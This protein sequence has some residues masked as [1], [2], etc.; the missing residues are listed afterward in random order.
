M[1]ERGRLYF[2]LD[3]FAD[4]VI[5][6][7]IALITSVP[8]I[9]IGTSIASLYYAL[10]K[11]IKNGEGKAIK[12]YLKVWA[13]NWKK[14]SILTGGYIVFVISCNV[15]LQR[16]ENSGVLFGVMLLL[17]ICSMLYCFP[18]IGRTRL[19]SIQCLQ[20]SLFW[21]VHH[22]AKTLFL[23]LN[24]LLCIIVFLIYPF[25]L[26]ILLGMFTYYISF[27]IEKILE[28]YSEDSN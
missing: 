7:I 2:A 8:I 16:M 11:S 14:G 13:E 17:L 18:L 25:F 9:T 12:L 1:E 24:F 21:T 6:G 28:E 23:L 20:V 26:P 5:L 3:K 27:P 19:N 4:I 15:V 10:W 22:P